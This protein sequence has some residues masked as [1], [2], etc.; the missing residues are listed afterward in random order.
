MGV[1]CCDDGKTG[2]TSK[3]RVHEGKAQLVRMS[4]VIV[5]VE[6]RTVIFC[7]LLAAGCW[8]QVVKAEDVEFRDE[9]VR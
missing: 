1:V 2:C 6:S 7:R 8:R 5:A 4:R 9:I 3:L